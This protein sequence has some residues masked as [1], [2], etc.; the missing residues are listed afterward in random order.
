MKKLFP[1]LL[2]LI[3]LFSFTG[4]EKKE[5]IDIAIILTE[6]KILDN[7][8]FLGAALD[9]VKRF[10]EG[11]NYSYKEY[12]PADSTA[13]DYRE[14]VEDAI[15]SGAKIMVM[16]GYLLETVTLEAQERY[17]QVK[18]ILLDGIPNNG[19][20]DETRV[21]EIAGNTYSVLY[22]EEQAGFLAGYAAVYDGYRKL[23]FFGGMSVPA[24]QRFGYGYMQGAEYA[25]GELELD[26]DSIE[27]RY[28]YCTSFNPAPEY[29][30]RASLWYHQGTEVIFACG[31][32]MGQS[33]IQA[34]IDADAKVIGVDTDQSGDSDTVITSAL[35]MISESVYQALHE[36][37]EG[38]FRGGH[39]EHLGADV[40][41]VG[42]SMET[43]RFRTF[44]QADY[45]RIYSEL[46]S[47]AEGITANILKDDADIFDIPLSRVQLIF[48]K[49]R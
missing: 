5:T 16:P 47:N 1:V 15:D 24:V 10:A 30:A 19:A 23:G 8:N 39:G 43:S 3:I 31:G 29:Q 48:E 13:E 44:T 28:L 33:V 4:C 12:F 38:E 7:N 37:D 17:P 45:D 32:A 41:G 27:M 9:G 22:A 26:Q 25:A 42:L 6:V 20:Y 34:S 40:G 36:W 11:T 14:C 2:V 21:E 18:F 35:K 49:L 46:A